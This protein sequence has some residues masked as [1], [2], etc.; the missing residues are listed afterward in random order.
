MAIAARA[1]GK[2]RYGRAN[3]C[4]QRNVGE[5]LEMIR[6]ERAAA[7]VSHSNKSDDGQKRDDEIGGGQ[8]S[9]A[10]STISAKPQ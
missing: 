10:R 5:I 2:H 9:A 3:K 6:H 7:E 4:D 1:I 8:K